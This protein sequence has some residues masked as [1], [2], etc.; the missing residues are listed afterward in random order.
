MTTSGF[1]CCQLVQHY[2]YFAPVICSKIML[3]A[4]HFSLLNGHQNP[5]SG[6][7]QIIVIWF[8]L[9]VWNGIFEEILVHISHPLSDFFQSTCMCSDVTFDYI[10]NIRSLLN[11]ATPVVLAS[12]ANVGMLN[13]NAL[14]VYTQ[15]SCCCTPT[16]LSVF[17]SCCDAGF[18]HIR[19]CKKT[20]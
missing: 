15:T 10:Q 2:K 16:C 11:M 7:N 5:V 9:H 1:T 4:S 18:M 14:L 8:Y 19:R 20:K 17:C 13:M 3:W 12:A 6:S